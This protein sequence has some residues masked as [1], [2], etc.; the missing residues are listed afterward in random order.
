M[1]DE[2]EHDAEELEEGLTDEGPGEKSDD[3]TMPAPAE[4]D[5]I[6]FSSCIECPYQCSHLE[7]MQLSGALILTVQVY[8]TLQEKGTSEAEE[9]EV[10]AEPAEAAENEKKKAKEAGQNEEAT[11]PQT[12]SGGQSPAPSGGTPTWPPATSASGQQGKS[13]PKVMVI[14]CTDILCEQGDEYAA[15]CMKALSLCCGSSV[16][17]HD[18]VFLL[19]LSY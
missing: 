12:S 13:T 16:M 17:S 6:S 3:D 7:H 18:V 9:T 19:F 1:E 14:N 4:I 2:T 8:G 11:A 5:V 15:A 10:L